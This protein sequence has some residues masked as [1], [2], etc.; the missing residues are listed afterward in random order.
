MR[1]DTRTFI[2]AN[3]AKAKDT[4]FVII[5]SF[6]TAN[7]IKRA[8][9]SHADAA[10]P[11]GVTAFAAIIKSFT[12]TSQSLDPITGNS[13]IG[14]ISYEIVDYT[15]QITTE[16]GA[17]LNSSRTLRRQRAQVYVGHKG[18]VWAD[19]AL[20]TTQF[21]DKAVSYYKGMY[22]ISCS[23]IQRESRV[24]IFKPYETNIGAALGK[25]DT[26]IT[27]TASGTT[28]F[29]M[30][31]HDIYYSDAPSVTVG[32]LEII[33]NKDEREIVRY[34]GKPSGSF[35]GVTR[36][37]FG[38]K[39]IELTFD[40][41]L[42]ADRQPKIKE[43]IYLEGPAPK[44]TYAVRTG[45]L[46]NQGGATLPAHWHQG[47]STTYVRL[48]D[49]T[50]Y[51]SDWWDTSD[52]VATRGFK[53]YFTGLQE[54]D[55][56]S[57]V[58]KEL[59]LLIGAFGPIYADG[60]VG[61]KRMAAVLSSSGYVAQLNASN[62][63]SYG[64]LTHDYARV[65]N[66]IEVEWNWDD[67]AQKYTRL[68]VFADT[69]SYTTYKSAP[70]YSIK[71]RGLNG[72]V[73]TTAMLTN[74]FAAIRDRY[75]GPPL[76]ITVNVLPSLNRLEVGD[77]VRLTLDQVRD[78]TGGTAGPIDRAFEVQRITTNW[79]TGDL[80]L[81]LFGSSKLAKW[82]P[83]SATTGSAI[84]DA[85]YTSAGTNL[86]A[87]LTIAGG[88][89]TASGTITGAST[90]A[91]ARYYYNGDLTINSGITVTGTQNVLL[92]IKGYLTI[93]GTLTTEGQGLAGVAPPTFTSG[94]LDSYFAAG[95]VGDIGTTHA[96]G[97]ITP[98]EVQGGGSQGFSTFVSAGAV[99]QGQLNAVPQPHL[100]W[101]G[102][103]LVGLPTSLRGSSGG[104]GGVVDGSDWEEG[105]FFAYGGTG[106]IGGG[107]LTII[108]RGLGFSGS[109]QIKTSGTVGTSGATVN[110]SGTAFVGGGGAGG[111][112]GGCLIVIDG[113]NIASPNITTS[114][115]VG[116]N[117]ATPVG[118]LFPGERTW[119]Y[120]SISG[121]T[122]T[123]DFIGNTALDHSLS[124]I[125]SYVTS[126]AGTSNCRVV[127]AEPSQTA[128]A[129]V[130]HIANV[131]ASV[132]VVEA[133][134]LPQTPAQNLATL[135][136]TVTPP[137]TLT[138]YSHSN[139][140]Y[141][142]T[143]TTPWTLA[144]P[145]DNVRTILAAMDGTS[146]EVE[147]RSVSRTN[148]ESATGARTT[149]VASNAK[150]GVNLATGNYILAGQT[151][152]DTGV[153]FYMGVDSG[154]PRMS[155][156]NSAGNKWAWNGTVLSIVG[157]ITATLGNI[158]GWL[159]GTTSLTSGSGTNTV[160]L[161]SGGTN[162]ALY[163]GSAT[164][165]SA[166]FRVT[167]AGALTAT[168]A[169]ITGAITA[170]SGTFTGTVQATS[171]GF[172][173]GFTPVTITTSGLTLTGAAGI[174]ITGSG[175]IRATNGAH[176]V[177]MAATG[178][179]AFSNTLG[180]TVNIPSDG[181]APTFASG[182]INSTVYNI[183][184]AGILRTST[185]VGDGSASGQ[186]VL[187]ND[188]G[189]K[190]Y[191]A[192]STVVQFF[193]SAATGAIKAI[194][195]AISGRI[196]ASSFATSGNFLTVA[197]VAADTV[198]TLDDTA[199]FAAS[200]SGQIVDSTNDRDAFSWTGKTATT[201]TGCTGVLAHPI[202]ASV[203]SLATSSKSILINDET[204]EIRFYGNRGDG[205]IEELAS[206]GVTSSGGDFIVGLFGSDNSS[207]MG[208]SGRSDSGT[209]GHGKSN[210]GNGL[211]G[212]ST[213][214]TGVNGE[215]SSGAG[216]FG[217][218]GSSVGVKCQT[219]STTQGA[220]LIVPKTSDTDPSAG[221]K[222][223]FYV[224]SS[225]VLRFHDGTSWKTVTV[226]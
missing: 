139:V 67:V 136:V 166:P 11:A 213:S 137:S 91:A 145:A 72:N 122:Y 59:Q 112:A 224:R 118:G 152:Y 163:A 201:L 82:V 78:Y 135:T 53:A 132:A 28:N 147:A 38:S 46:Y 116:Q 39:P 12:S 225:G 68:N 195:A 204:N 159:L 215:S 15:S 113:N 55:G 223:E 70:K 123:S 89:V 155:M 84:S 54:T 97:V 141:R 51:G 49:F 157:T 5:Q 79:I 24:K 162:P 148:G 192:S 126:V 76:R 33:K 140:Y 86:A 36:G 214:A 41:A 130:P 96:G 56:K 218:S 165:G 42:S 102:T 45:V 66:L 196:S 180:T 83:L 128:V 47:I 29:Q 25:T 77:T 18:D 131:P 150:G 106:G 143:G 220:L 174:N 208:M 146:Y 133:Q 99:T 177:Q 198:L 175:T 57:F 203:V 30:V 217:T 69:D 186:G 226:V 178:F 34:T 22:K 153:G 142:V 6:D 103:N 107:G 88:A 200:G 188:T 43:Y 92:F 60:A 1:S 8:F 105:P 111:A 37:V 9:T 4:R 172:G 73:S 209:G 127:Y 219:S 179:T 121:G 13:T 71:F 52:S 40:A 125:S 110:S 7:T 212:Y 104:S 108:C 185:T 211:F 189:I 23:D 161:D 26:T 119:S 158:G 62:V 98:I 58:E 100:I 2:Q 95:T 191:K 93:N 167:Q 101:D 221:T 63:V 170:T 210:T 173:T 154:T 222:G 129:D 164:P 64:E 19:Y 74:Q 202:G 17:Q 87:V 216:V 199:D 94:S 48:A 44:L 187:I 10:L 207:R 65:H 16:L 50:S 184:S 27:V 197:A 183:T 31:A 3:A 182:I 151:A 134:N 144:G 114:T 171:G 90:F 75:A 81:D 115:F 169:T 20:I 117:G 194:S 61:L 138:G 124:G 85:H 156:G 80:S 176:Y 21:V 109:G 160:G 205:T 149:I 35:T 14:D 190:G 120:Q 168:N 193:L 206:I 32:Y 181:S